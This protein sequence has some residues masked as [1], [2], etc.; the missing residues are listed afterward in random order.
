MIMRILTVLVVAVL[1][2]P[3]AE[4]TPQAEAKKKFRNKTSTQT[5][6]NT[7]AIAV[8]G[9]GTEGNANP[10]PSTIVVSGFKKGKIL[11]VNVT[12]NNISH[13]NP[14]EID[15]LLVA[16][17]GQPALLKNNA[18]GSDD[19]TDV[20]VTFDDEAV[21]LISNDGPLIAGTFRP[22]I[23]PFPSE[24]LAPYAGLAAADGSNPNGTWQLFV[25]DD[26]AGDTGT[27]AGGWTLT[28]QAKEKVKVKKK[29][30]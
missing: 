19:V 27:I 24:T 5:F 21:A 6:S 1:V 2:L 13:T 23:F 26:G 20:T 8:P 18:G 10:F 12:V 14:D 9:T 7:A 22:S 3:L 11:D 4:A 16:P 30:K 15:I 28:I 29:K 25:F 17:N